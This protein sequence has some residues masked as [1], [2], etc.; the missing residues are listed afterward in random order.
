[1]WLILA[2]ISA[3]FLGFYDASKK[4]A[5]KNNAVLPVLFLNTV[6][7]TLI[8]S[9]FLIDYI[10]GFGWFSGTLLDTAPFHCDAEIIDSQ[11]IMTSSSLHNARIQILNATDRQAIDNQITGAIV[12]REDGPLAEP[13]AA[14]DL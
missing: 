1:M 10:G 13:P 7:S 9:P 12:K 8:F 4:A 3:T 2:F 5:L 11:Q 14:L 6:F